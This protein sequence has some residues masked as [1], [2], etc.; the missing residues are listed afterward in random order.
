MGFILTNA[1][2]RAKES[3]FDI[4]S[5]NSQRILRNIQHLTTVL[6][7]QAE[8]DKLLSGKF[9]SAAKQCERFF[10]DEQNDISDSSFEVAN[11]LMCSGIV[12]LRYKGGFYLLHRGSWQDYYNKGGIGAMSYIQAQQEAK[13][14]G[15]KGRFQDAINYMHKYRTL[16]R[17]FSAALPKSMPHYS[18]IK[19]I[20]KRFL[21][22]FSYELFFSLPRY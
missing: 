8:D 11:G 19:A 14:M 7:Y 1:L 21:E 4:D 15:I 12:K 5:P 10:D 2:Q 20:F 17:N 3:V 18:E 9:H 6:I 22:L 16:V 13:A